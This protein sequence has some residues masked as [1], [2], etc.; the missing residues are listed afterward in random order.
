MKRPNP[1]MTGDFNRIVYKHG[2]K[3]YNTVYSMLGNREESEEVVQ[4]VFCEAYKSYASF[5][6]DSSVTTWLYRIMMNVVSD[7]I[8]RKK[9]PPL[10]EDGL[11][12]EEHEAVGNLPD[13]SESAENA[14]LKKQRLLHI[15]NALLK[16]PIPYRSVFVFSAIEGYNSV[17]IGKIMGISAGTV[18]IRLFRAVKMLRAML[19]PTAAFKEEDNEKV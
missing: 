5:K 18:R 4:E 8:K 15:R 7:H 12:I 10:I 1:V 11:S 2:S 9:R 17:E 16:L 3:I 6:G 19:A 14:F 13:T